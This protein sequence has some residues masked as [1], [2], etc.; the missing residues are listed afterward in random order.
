MLT[1]GQTRWSTPLFVTM[2]SPSF[3]SAMARSMLAGERAVEPM[4][5]RVR[6]TLGRNWRWVRALTERY[7]QKFGSHIRPRQRDV[8]E[9][10]KLDDGLRDA[11]ARHKGKLRIAEW[12]AEP[13]RMQPA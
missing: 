5:A 7:V 12:L 13:M 3:Y 9:F 1:Q 11:K 2:L 4:T 6:R 10:L 8:V